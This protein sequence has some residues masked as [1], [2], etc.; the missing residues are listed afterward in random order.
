MELEDAVRASGLRPRDSETAA[1]LT[2][3]VLG[4][5]DVDRSAIHD[6]AALYREARFSRHP[7]DEADRE[8]AIAALHRLHADLSVVDLDVLDG[9]PADGGRAR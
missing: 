4:S 6:L 5:L 2:G 9:Q 8:A 3:R 1:E 7:M